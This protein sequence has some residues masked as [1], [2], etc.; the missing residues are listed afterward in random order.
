MYGAEAGVSREGKNLPGEGGRGP[1]SLFCRNSSPASPLN[2]RGPGIGLSMRIKSCLG[3]RENE[4]E[5]K[6]Q[7]IQS[8]LIRCE[9]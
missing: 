3:V 5:R 1:G 9:I 6:Q 4:Q 8:L 2:C 7:A